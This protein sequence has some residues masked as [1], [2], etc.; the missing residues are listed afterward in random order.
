MSTTQYCTTAATR[1]DFIAGLAGL[2]TL[3]FIPTATLEMVEFAPEQLPPAG[4]AER[5]AKIDA[6][7]SRVDETL[8]ALERLYSFLH[9]ARALPAESV[10]GLRFVDLDDQA[11]TEL[12]RLALA[13]QAGA[14]TDLIFA[15][16][17]QKEWSLH[18]KSYILKGEGSRDRWQTEIDF[19]RKDDP[20]RALDLQAFLNANWRGEA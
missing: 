15:M 10:D 5:T 16:S 8:I 6:W 7:I 19:I 11:Q 20:A 17:G 2:A 13:M 12:E 4:P 18:I 3:A 1:R 14:Y 9:D